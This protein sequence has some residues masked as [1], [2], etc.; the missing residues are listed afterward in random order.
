MWVEHNMCSHCQTKKLTPLCDRNPPGMGFDSLK[1][2]TLA[3]LSCPRNGGGVGALKNDGG[4][5]DG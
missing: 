4:G 2:K 3:G 5:G 1:C